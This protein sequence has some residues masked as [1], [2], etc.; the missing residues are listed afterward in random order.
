V[1]R[2][3]CKF[4]INENKQECKYCHSWR[5]AF[6]SFKKRNTSHLTLYCVQFTH[7]RTEEWFYKIGVTSQSVDER[8]DKDRERFDIK[9]IWEVRTEMYEAL[10]KESQMLYDLQVL[11]GRKYNPVALFSGSSECF[12]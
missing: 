12:I 11:Q 2:I 4:H 5:H 9:V 3:K 10:S 8:F 1:E 6:R 7:Y